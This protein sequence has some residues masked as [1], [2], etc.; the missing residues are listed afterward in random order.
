[1]SVA[2]ARLAGPAEAEIRRLA[3]AAHPQE[4]CGVLI[5]VYEADAVAI[6]EATSGHNL[7]AETRSDRYAVD[8]D[9]IQAADRRAR[10]R[11]RDVV[12]FWHSHPDHPARPSQ[13][14]SDRAWDGYA[15]LIVSSVV[16]GSGDLNAFSVPDEGRGLVPIPLLPA[17]DAG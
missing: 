11:G 6:L 8:P 10:A 13:L 4:G 7:W 14:D 2:S 3:A 12:G 1:V 5:G 15:Y 16:G 9:D 17:E